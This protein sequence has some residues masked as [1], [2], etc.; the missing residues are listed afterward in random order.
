[1]HT[2]FFNSAQATCHML[3]FSIQSL[4]MNTSV[5][6]TAWGL[7]RACSPAQPLLDRRALWGL[8]VEMA[9]L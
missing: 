2:F 1:M 7:T 9:V 5:G 8:T 4:K 6:V 3:D